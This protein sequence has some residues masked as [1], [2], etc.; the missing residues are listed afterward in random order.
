[1]RTSSLRLWTWTTRLQGASSSLGPTT[2]RCARVFSSTSSMAQK[3]ALRRTCKH[4]GGMVLVKHGTS[5]HEKR[6]ARE[7]KRQREFEKRVFESQ[8][9]PARFGSFTCSQT[10]AIE[11]REPSP[12]DAEFAYANGCTDGTHTDVELDKVGLYTRFHT[13]ARLRAPG[14]P[15]PRGVPH[16]AHAARLLR[17]VLGRRG[18]RAVGLGRHERAHLEGA[19]GRAAGDHAAEGEAQARV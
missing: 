5:A 2:A 10:K 13:G 9:F 4:T 17:Q 1:M 15:Q 16:E 14:G 12:N 11:S 18:L 6:P 8:P 19:R 7:R 3:L